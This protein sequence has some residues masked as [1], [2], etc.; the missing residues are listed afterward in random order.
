MSDQ[1]GETMSVT[2]AVTKQPNQ[3]PAPVDIPASA[4]PIRVLL[5]GSAAGARI[6]I[7]QLQDEPSVVIAGHCADEDGWV[8]LA[9][10]L[11]AD[12]VVL[13][14]PSTDALADWDERAD[15]TVPVVVIVERFAAD[16]LRDWIAQ[17]TS[18]GARSVLTANPTTAELV[19]AIQGSVAGLVTLSPELGQALFDSHQ[20]A[21]DS[22]PDEEQAPEH[23]TPREREVLEMMMEGLSNKEIAADLNV[24][25][26][27]V[28][29]HISS[30]LGK[31]GAASRTE[32][33]TVAL[34][35]GL[36]TI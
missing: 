27:T 30:I 4:R 28:K 3:K 1:P 24:S 34:R 35:R 20:P 6:R 36:I 25:V 7:G 32:A 17:A 14:L 29:F 2:I 9:A 18:P 13:D 22:M 31:L 33:T 23:L 21:G 12:V 16:C 15:Y 11:D 10:Q 5:A 19:G 8:A 26:H